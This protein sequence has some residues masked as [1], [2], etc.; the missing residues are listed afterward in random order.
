MNVLKREKQIMVLSML[1]EGNS[2][3]SIERMTGVQKR[4]ITRL[5]VRVGTDCERYLETHMRNLECYRLELDEI[6]TFCGKKE[7]HLSDRERFAE[8]LGDQ[9][10]FYAID[11]KTKLI[12]TWTVG[13]RDTP[14]T[15]IFIRRLKSSL[16]GVK[17]QISTDAFT[18]YRYAI[19]RVFGDSVHYATITKQYASEAVGPGRYAPP[20]VKGTVKATHL[21]TPDDRYI[22]TSYIERHNLTIRTFIR[23]FARLSLG[24]S[25]KRDNL[26]AAVALYFAYYNY[27]WIPRTTGQTPAMAAGVSFAPWNMEQL[28]QAVMN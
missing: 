11:P 2:I 1:V 27:C 8:D 21:G 3:R 5:M 4:T 23:R 12:P 18:P 24:F 25:K 14:T 15:N 7:R 13:K 26:K 16:N 17:P 28:L 9:F 19:P 6:W 20:C 10:V 22:C